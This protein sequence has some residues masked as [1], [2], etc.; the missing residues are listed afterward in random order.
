MNNSNLI[1]S[2]ERA[3]FLSKGTRIQ[4]LQKAPIKLFY[5]KI[6]RLF[7]MLSGKPIKLGPK[8]FGVKVWI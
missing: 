6:L 8:P 1:K 4:K 3:V 7:S 2:L 5:T